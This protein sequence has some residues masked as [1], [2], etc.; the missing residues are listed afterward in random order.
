MSYTNTYRNNPWKPSTTKEES[1]DKRIERLDME[2][3]SLFT[4]NGCSVRDV[5]KHAF[6]I[7]RPDFNQEIFKISIECAIKDKY[8]GRRNSGGVVFSVDGNKIGDS[9]KGG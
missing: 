4:C 2:F 5:C 7:K 1:H 9:C 3:K 6:T 8:C